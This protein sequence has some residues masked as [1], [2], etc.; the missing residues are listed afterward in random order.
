LAR[1]GGREVEQHAE[2]RKLHAVIP[3]FWYPQGLFHL[4]NTSVGQVSG[5]GNVETENQVC[6]NFAHSRG[7]GEVA[8]TTGVAKHRERY[9]LWC[10][11]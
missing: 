10:H 6:N 11:V 2:K 7:T 5:R 9:F 4:E 8:I 1:G 3:T